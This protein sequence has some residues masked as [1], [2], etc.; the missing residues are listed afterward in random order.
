MGRT[1]W[2]APMRDPAYIGKFLAQLETGWLED[3]DS[4]FGQFVSNVTRRAFR[5]PNHPPDLETVTDDQFLEALAASRRDLRGRGETPER[6]G[7]MAKPID[8]R[9]A[10]TVRD[11][12][13]QYDR[14]AMQT[15]GRIGRD[16]NRI[17][18]FLGR[19]ALAWGRRSDLA[20][21]VF[22]LSLAPLEVHPERP[23]EKVRVGLRFLEE[24]D[25]LELMER[26]GSLTGDA[27]ER[28]YTER[29]P[30]GS[31]IRRLKPPQPDP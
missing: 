31:L 27:V 8:P 11:T 16:P 21:C 5:K 13:R 14:W 3:P 18:P 7:E 12:S 23:G 6:E 17:H 15:F 1:G 20:F 28:S 2:G 29:G 25:F 26:P 10:E 24:D 4:R 22:V 30:L 9:I 19:F